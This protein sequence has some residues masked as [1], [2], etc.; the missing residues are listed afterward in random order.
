MPPMSGGL[1]CI[2]TR[3]LVFTCAVLLWSGPDSSGQDTGDLG[4]WQTRAPS[5]TERSE[6]TAAALDG[7]IYLIGGFNKP[8]LGNLGTLTISNDVDAYDPATDRWTVKAALP[9]VLHHAGAA[10]V[11]GRVYVIGGFTKSFLYVWSPVATMYIYDPDA[12]HWTKGPP[13][14]TARGALA[15]TESG[16]KIFAIGGYG[17]HG[18]SGA[19]EVY[20]P[21]SKT[22]TARAPLPTPRDHLAVAAVGAKIYAIGGRLDIDYGRNLAVTEAYD[23]QTDHW[24]KV[25]NLPTARSGITA[26]VIRG[27]IFVLGGE[28]PEGTFRTNEAYRPDEDRWRTMAPMP[29]GRHGLGSAVVQDRLYILSGGR[30]PGGSYSNVNEVFVPPSGWTEDRSD[31]QPRT[32]ATPNQ[33]GTVMALLATF[34]NAGVLPPESDPETSRLIKALIQFQAAFMKSRNPSVRGLLAS[35]LEAK[36]GGQAPAAVEAFRTDGWTSQSLEAVVDYAASPSVW[37]DS[38]LESGLRDYNIGRRDFELLTRI[39]L[40]A[41]SRFK[42][43]GQDFHQIY[44][45]RRPEMPGS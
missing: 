27:T 24:T 28:A 10:T 12:D 19:V 38:E 3:L 44:A 36:F 25:A 23:T 42:A 11:G 14:P 40:A 35:A 32:R 26:G 31:S 2:Q 22:W 29:T 17:E 16:G 34:E 37:N 9:T 5:S 43:R 13:M 41:R 45:A 30:T 15:V 18:N 21:A 6:V 20:D 8:N 7:T 39:F 33:V 4:T 1:S